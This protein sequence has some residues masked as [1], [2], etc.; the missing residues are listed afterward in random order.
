[1]NAVS[2][3]MTE[4]VKAA[5]RMLAQLSQFL[6]LVLDGT[7]QQEVTLA[8]ELHLTRLYL[9]IGQTR[10][11]SRLAV[12]YDV[13]PDTLG[14]LLPTLLLQPV[15]ENAVRHGIAPRAGAGELAVI[16]QKQDD[17]LILQ[18]KDNSQGDVDTA[19]R[20]LGLRN[21]ESRLATLYGPDYTFAVETAPDRGHC[22]HLSIPFRQAAAGPPIFTA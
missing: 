15:V 9:E 10:F 5:R 8:Q 17:R 20:G 4:D 11:P 14:A 7:D 19:A 22:L 2:A 13:A 3:L 1:M 16:T 6:R 21:L 12:H 18:V